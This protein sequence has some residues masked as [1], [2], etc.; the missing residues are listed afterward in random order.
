MIKIGPSILT[1][2]FANLEEELK[3]ASDADYFHLDVMDGNFVPNLT[4]G[5]KLIK[6]LRK[7]TQKIFD[8]HLMVNNPENFIFPMQK[9]GVDNFIF[10]YEACTHCDRI[11][12]EIK[13]NG[14]NAGIAIVPSTNENCLEYLLGDIDIILIMTVN[15]GFG[16]QQFLTSQL[17]KI[18]KVRK[19]IDKSGRN[20]ELE[21]DGG[22]NDKT[23]KNVVNAGATMAVAGSYVFDSLKEYNLNIQKLRKAAK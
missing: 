5:S 19:M 6:D 8:V 23:I 13:K 17:K 4:F 21:V 14:M 22:I 9:A 16:G 2:D 11:I 18:E 3:L 1:A 12:K 10:H 15:P 7:H 20:I